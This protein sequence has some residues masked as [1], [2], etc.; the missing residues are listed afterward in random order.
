MTD[1]VDRFTAFVLK[2]CSGLIAAGILSTAG[3][4]YNIGSQ[5]AVLQDQMQ[6][7]ESRTSGLYTERQ[8]EQD[9]QAIIHRLNTHEN[10]IDN[11]DERL[12]ALEGR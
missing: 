8:A 9:Q 12:R 1:Q 11:A 5:L 3:L 7:M 4:L 6:R 2:L 10:R